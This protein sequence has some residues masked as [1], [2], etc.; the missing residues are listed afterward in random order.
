[1]RLRRI[2]KYSWSHLQVL[3]QN[4]SREQVSHSLRGNLSR[5]RAPHVLYMVLCMKV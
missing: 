2:P 4:R 1:M 5:L 3:I